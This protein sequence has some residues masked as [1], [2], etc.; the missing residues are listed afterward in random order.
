MGFWSFGHISHAKPLESRGNGEAWRHNTERYPVTSNATE[1][2]LGGPRAT[3]RCDGTV[4][5]M[6]RLCRAVFPIF[7]FAFLNKMRSP[8]PGAPFPPYR[9]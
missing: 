6:F 3:Q 2:F 1:P 5:Q 9:S 7:S 8:P 4:F